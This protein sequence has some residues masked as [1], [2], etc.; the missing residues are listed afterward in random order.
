M[1]ERHWFF[2]F[3]KGA[4]TYPANFL[5]A[6][7]NLA[8]VIPPVPEVFR[9]ARRDFRSMALRPRL[10]TGLPLSNEQMIRFQ[11]KSLV[12]TRLAK[13]IETIS[14]SATWQS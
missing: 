2:L 4:H 8:I 13:N 6:F 9:Y 10:S 1:M 12:F 5:V 11:K 14:S 7:G 3:D